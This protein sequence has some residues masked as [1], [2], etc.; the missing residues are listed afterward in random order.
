MPPNL[1]PDADFNKLVRGRHGYLLYNQN[2]TVVGLSVARYGEY[3][4]SEVD[5]FR[6]MI[7]PGARVAD[8]GANIGTHTVAMAR[9]VGEG[10]WVT[11]VEPQ[12]LVFQTLCANVALNSLTN[13][14]CQN[15]AVSN[16]KEPIL[17]E[18]LDPRAAVN[19]GG[20]ELGHSA[21]NRSVR[22]T[23]LDDFLNGE[24]LDFMKI[25]IQGMEEACLRGARETLKR[26]NTILYMENDQAEK[27]PPLLAYLK[28]LGYAAYWHLPMFYNQN[29]FAADPVNVHAV[30]YFETGDP[31][32]SCNGFAINM[33][34]VP[35]AL[36]IR[37]NGLLEVTDFFEHPLTREQN[38][39]HGACGA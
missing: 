9:I 32:L 8:L 27:S 36:G 26:Y 30:G 5:I 15:M 22:C 14:D 23:R 3:F 16:T 7:R 34:C 4:E 10:G 1:L 29:N 17:V 35:N 12:R 25:D 28:E 24:R 6:R 20:L 18:E 33:L 19:F 2:D 13:V 31:F 39:F 37:V 11:A 21:A 38:R